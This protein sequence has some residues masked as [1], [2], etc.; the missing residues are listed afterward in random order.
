MNEKE[1]RDDPLKSFIILVPE[2]MG[3]EANGRGLG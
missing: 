3:G 1:A 2:R